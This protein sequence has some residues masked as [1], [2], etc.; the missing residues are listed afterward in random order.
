MHS[1]GDFEAPFTG[2]NK[3]EKFRVH[4]NIQILYPLSSDAIK[5]L[6]AQGTTAMQ[7]SLKN[8]RYNDYNIHKKKYGVIQRLVNCIGQE[9]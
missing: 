3:S 6:S 1:Y 8:E 5:A 9:N 2:E 7:I 4:W